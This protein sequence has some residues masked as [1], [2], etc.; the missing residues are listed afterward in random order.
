MP[1]QVTLDIFSG[2]VNPTWELS[3][4]QEHQL[5]GLLFSLSKRS[6]LK[7]SA[8][9]Q[10]LGYNGFIISSIGLP[11]LPVTMLVKSNLVDFGWMNDSFVDNDHTIEKWLLNSGGDFVPPEVKEIVGVQLNAESNDYR[12]YIDKEN[13]LV[14]ILAEPPYNPGWWNDASRVLL[15][16]CYNYGCD[17]ATNTIAQPGLGSGKP[18]TVCECGDVGKASVRDGL[19]TLASPASTPATGHYVAL[20][21]APGVDFH[22]YR[23]DNNGKWSHKRGRTPAINYDQDGALITDPAKAARGIYSDFCGYY[24]VK[25]GI[26]KI[27]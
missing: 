27:R 10:G 12:F 13:G 19:I 11:G 14:G 20:V 25:P 1:I 8:T 4:E 17:I 6:L 18:F 26:V 15:N 9:F 22:W 7:A 24:H 5:T 23:R 21:I 2:R 16:N 3:N